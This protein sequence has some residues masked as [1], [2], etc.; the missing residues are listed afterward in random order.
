MARFD[1]EANI[2]WAA[3]PRGGRRARGVRRGRLQD[4]RQDADGGAAR[5]RRRQSGSVLRR[6][7]HLGTGNY[8]PRTARLYTDFGLLTCNEESVRRRQRSLQAAHRPGQGEQ[9]AT[10][11][12]RRRSPCTTPCSPPSATKP[13]TP[14]AGKRARIIAKMNA[15]LEPEIIEA[16]YDASQAGVKIDLI[17]RGVCALRPGIDGL[18]GE[19]PACARSSAASSNT[20]AS[21]T[22]TPTA[23]RRCTC[24]AP[25]GWTAISS[26]ASSCASRCSTPSS[27][28]ASSRK[29]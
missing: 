2:N 3:K 29:A 16:L 17:V 8:H 18:V 27:S 13:P 19:H 4:P 11:C 21:S 15:L 12:G 28:G 20:R 1:E 14:R 10:T 25:T 7:V 5:G 9:A 23:R 26:A 6:Y 22:S 24:P